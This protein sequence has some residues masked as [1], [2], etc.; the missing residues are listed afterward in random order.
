MIVESV[1]EAAP[2]RKVAYLPKLDEAARYVQSVLQPDDLVLTLGAGDITT[3]HD[4]L[5]AAG[6]E[7]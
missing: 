1:C 4:R 6:A 7:W 5:V 2:G 3:L